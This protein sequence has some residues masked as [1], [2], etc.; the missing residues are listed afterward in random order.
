MIANGTATRPTNE[1]H[2]RFEPAPADLTCDS[3]DSAASKGSFPLSTQSAP[4]DARNGA[5]NTPLKTPNMLSDDFIDYQ[6]VFEEIRNDY[7]VYAQETSFQ[8]FWARVYPRQA[9]LV[10]AYTVTTFKALRCPIASLK[11]GEVLPAIQ[12]LPKHNSLVKQLY[13]I[14]ADAGLVTSVGN[15]YIRTDKAVDPTGTNMLLRNVLRDFPKHAN[16]H[17]L[18][19]TTGSK[20]AACLTGSS[21]PLQMLFGAKADR[22]L[23]A[24][25]YANGPMYKAISKLLG[26]FLLKAYK[27]PRKTFKI[28]EIGAGTGGTT[29]YIV[30]CLEE[31]GVRFHYTFSDVSGCLVAAARRYFA[32]R[33][34]MDFISLDVENPVPEHHLEKYDTVISTNCIHATK[35]ITQSLTHIRGLLR[36]DGFVC[37]VEFTRNMFW[38]DL[39]F[40]L[41]EGWWL[42]DDGRTHVLADTG[43]WTKAIKDAGF[44][45]VD[46]T[47]GDS[48]EAQT[49]RIISGFTSQP[50]KIPVPVAPIWGS[51]PR[52]ETIVWK[53]AG[54]KALYADIYIPPT[55]THRKSPVGKLIIP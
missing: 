38:F 23:L 1:V 8:G 32:G 7:D 52:I 49:L 31:H 44:Q 42:F 50:R 10:L 6:Q 40:G 43:V 48:E 29:K 2:T 13:N 47:D 25:V 21:D 17:R 15:S 39:V 16:E 11:K 12:Y 45:A 37:L 3:A 54:T 46:F 34:N 5:Q 51:K 26:S 28:L 33:D 30:K 36:K 35:D 24:D 53:T 20:L 19:S 22:D 4:Y 18:L 9:Q 14:L 41:L 55:K 27:Q